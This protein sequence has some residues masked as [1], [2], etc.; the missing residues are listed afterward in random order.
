MSLNISQSKQGNTS[1]LRILWGLEKF[2]VMSAQFEKTIN[3]FSWIWGFLSELM[4]MVWSIPRLKNS[5]VPSDDGILV[6]I[7]ER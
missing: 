3:F 1:F 6:S 2:L 4:M 5:P 7:K